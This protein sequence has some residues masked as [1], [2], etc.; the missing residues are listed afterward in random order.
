MLGRA[1]AKDKLEQNSELPPLQ[2]VAKRQR[3]SCSFPRSPYP[4][5]YSAKERQGDTSAPRNL[6]FNLGGGRACLTRLSVC[7][8]LTIFLSSLPGDNRLL[9]L[10]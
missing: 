2:M 4:L 9:L 1:R 8:S 10:L 3:S 7:C 5:G 6:P